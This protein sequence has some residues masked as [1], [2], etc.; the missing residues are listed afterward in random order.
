MRQRQEASGQPSRLPGALQ[1]PVCK[2]TDPEG[3]E[4]SAEC[5]DSERRPG[6]AA[7]GHGV[8]PCPVVRGPRG[9]CGSEARPPPPQGSF[10]SRPAPSLTWSRPTGPQALTCLNS[11]A[12]ATTRSPTGTTEHHR[13]TDCLSPRQTNGPVWCIVLGAG[14]PCVPC[15]RGSTHPF[16]SYLHRAAPPTGTPKP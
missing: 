15:A 8:V 10:S 5:A 2:Q 13:H 4:P 14:R 12:D 7:P 1:A 16:I 3:F 9:S 6:H 11:M